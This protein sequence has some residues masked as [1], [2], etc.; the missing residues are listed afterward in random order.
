M[1]IASGDAMTTARE[2]KD[3]VVGAVQAGAAGDVDAFLA[4]MHP[5][6]EVHEPPYLPYGGTYRLPPEA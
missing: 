6:I 4:A 5:E 3:L 2:N 1:V